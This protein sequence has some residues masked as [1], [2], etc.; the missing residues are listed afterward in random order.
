[1][2]FQQ[3]ILT[4]WGKIAP[5]SKINLYFFPNKS[6]LLFAT[7][8]QILFKMRMK[9]PDFDTMGQDCTIFKNKSL[10]FTK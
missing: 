1:M 8:F 9:F 10:L 2:T 3:K 5:F 4:P 7:N 6:N